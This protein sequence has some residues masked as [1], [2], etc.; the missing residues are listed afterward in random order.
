MISTVKKKKHLC[1]RATPSAKIQ[2]RAA[3]GFHPNLLKR[4][5]ISRKNYNPLI[6]CLLFRH[7]VLTQGISMPHPE[8]Q[9]V[10]WV[11]LVTPGFCQATS[12]CT[13]DLRLALV[14][15]FIVK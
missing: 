14:G 1:R 11:M 2:E 13:V 4:N 15:F 7:C 5:S 6:C 8:T 9:T 3:L 12:R 10:D